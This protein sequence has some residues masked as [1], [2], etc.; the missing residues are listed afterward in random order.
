[1]KF[2]RG[3]NASCKFTTPRVVAEDKPSTVRNS[4]TTLGQSSRLQDDSEGGED[5][6]RGWMVAGGK[7]PNHIFRPPKARR[8]R[9]RSA[10]GNH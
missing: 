8:V 6:E 9:G 3:E 10:L 4:L 7:S 2:Q 5:R 1:V